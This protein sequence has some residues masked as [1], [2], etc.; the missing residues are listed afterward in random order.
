MK[1]WRV[2]L[3]MALMLAC[4]GLSVL[5]TTG[6][7]HAQSGIVI[8]SAVLSIYEVNI[9]GQNA[10][11]HVITAPWSE[12]GVTWASFGNA[13]DPTAILSF[14]TDDI[15]WIELNVTAQVQSWVNNP[16]Q[17]FGLLLEQ[18]LTYF[19]TFASSESTDV[20]LRPK[21]D[22]CF[23]RDGGPE[24]CVTIQRTENTQHPVADAYIFESSPDYNG[25]TAP[26]LYTGLI[27]GSTALKYAM[28]RFELSS[29]TA[30]QL[31]SL[32]VRSSVESGPAL[33]ALGAAGIAGVIAFRLR[34]RR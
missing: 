5:P 19:T 21:L 32:T 33:L 13:F 14:R 7:V 2:S 3:S 23:T 15:G 12:T 34:R 20:A 28:L 30:V 24:T 27:E 17:N 4:L 1:H 25:G 18:G 10:Y 8:N 9:S 16:S 31:Q 29:V 6:P 22:V 26:L 11:V